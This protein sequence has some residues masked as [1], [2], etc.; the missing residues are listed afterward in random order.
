MVLTKDDKNIISIESWLQ[1]K[2]RRRPKTKTKCD[3]GATIRG[4]RT[5][6][7]GRYSTVVTRNRSCI[8]LET[9]YYD[10]YYGLKN[11]Y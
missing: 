8:M 4:F 2:K 5:E 6:D 3:N 7:C 10:Y 1:K 11:D 9:D